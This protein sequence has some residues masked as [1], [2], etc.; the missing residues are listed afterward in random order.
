MRWRDKGV[1]TRKA[2][3]RATSANGPGGDQSVDLGER[4]RLRFFEPSS[5]SS[6]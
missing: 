1:L 3:S 2:I 4:A 6:A 5:A